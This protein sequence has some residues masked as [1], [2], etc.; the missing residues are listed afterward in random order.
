MGAEGAEAVMMLV[1][2]MSVSA[3][4]IS[5]HRLCTSLLFVCAVQLPPSPVQLSKHSGLEC[6]NVLEL[7]DC[8]GVKCSSVG[9]I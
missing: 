4:A 1:N 9:S 3:R 7:S 5:I 2:T 8:L 6:R